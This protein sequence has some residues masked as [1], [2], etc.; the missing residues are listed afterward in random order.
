MDV[1]YSG[2]TPKNMNLSLHFYNC[3]KMDKEAMMAK[4]SRKEIVSCDF[5][6]RRPVQRPTIDR[7]RMGLVKPFLTERLLM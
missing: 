6:F 1:W 4:I 7:F 5:S 2:T 3:I